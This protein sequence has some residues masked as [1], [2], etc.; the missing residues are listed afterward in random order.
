MQKRVLG[1]SLEVSAVGFGCM[2]LNFGYA[3]PVSKDEGIRLIRSA[4]ER[5]VTFF[6]TAEVYGPFT[7]EEMVG[8][9]L[10]PVRD[11]VVIVTKFGF[12]IDPATNKQAGMDSRP[13]HI[14]EPAHQCALS[15]VHDGS[16]WCRGDGDGQHGGYSQPGRAGGSKHEAVAW[17]GA[18]PLSQQPHQP[19]FHRR[20][21]VDVAL[22]H[23]DRAMTGQLLDVP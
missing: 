12:R 3:N 11:Q 6:D 20:V 23:L 19:A 10:R 7:N 5:G 17:S 15:P 13:E 22:R 9:A 18:W 14:V 4:V 8:E 1:E 16:P 21:A 2:G